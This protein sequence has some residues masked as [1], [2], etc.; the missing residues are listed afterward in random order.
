MSRASSTPTLKQNFLPA[1]L[2]EC[3]DQLVQGV[4]V[5]AVPEVDIEIAAKAEIGA[6][7]ELVVYHAEQFHTRPSS[8]AISG[9]IRKASPPTS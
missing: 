2:A 6:A 4:H 7:Q 9:M 5:L 1:V 8:R 3:E